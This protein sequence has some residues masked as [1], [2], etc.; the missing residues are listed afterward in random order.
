MQGTK[1]VEKEY[2]TCHLRW[3]VHSFAVSKGLNEKIVLE[4]K[5]RENFKIFSALQ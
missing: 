3:T 2:L 1:P 4:S 5:Y